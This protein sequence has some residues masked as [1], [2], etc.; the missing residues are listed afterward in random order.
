MLILAT[1]NS[2]I[3]CGTRELLDQNV[4]DSL[5]RFK[6]SFL[7]CSIATSQAQI[8]ISKAT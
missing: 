8:G 6:N 3:E 7:V 1:K 2:K 5:T 4:I